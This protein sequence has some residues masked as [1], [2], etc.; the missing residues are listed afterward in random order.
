V[1]VPAPAAPKVSSPP[2]PRAS[3]PPGQVNGVHDKP[4]EGVAAQSPAHAEPNGVHA[5]PNGFDEF[6]PRG[7]VPGIYFILF[8]Q[9]TCSS[10]NQRNGNY[11]H[12]SF[13]L[14]LYMQEQLHG[15]FFY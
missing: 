13:F 7:S 6:D 11:M 14:F 1:S 3:S 4:V 12:A 10:I 9:S 5:E 8:W 2:I 15:V